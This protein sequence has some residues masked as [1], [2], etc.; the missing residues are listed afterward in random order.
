MR[1]Q[2]AGGAGER[3]PHSPGRGAG[4][5]T[6]SCPRGRDE[7]PAAGRGPPARPPPPALPPGHKENGSP[8]SVKKLERVAL[9]RKLFCSQ[10]GPLPPQTPSRTETETRVGSGL[11]TQRWLLNSLAP[12]FHKGFPVPCKHCTPPLSPHTSPHCGHGVKGRGGGG[13]PEEPR[14]QALAPRRRGNLS[15]ECSGA[16]CTSRGPGRES[17]SDLQGGDRPCPSGPQEA[18]SHSSLPSL[19]HSSTRSTNRY[20]RRV[21]CRLVLGWS[22]RR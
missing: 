14:I 21:T 5:G 12:H 20:R 8:I 15:L 18:G 2:G 10:E 11:N 4:Q 13:R 9:A 16:S 19:I 22:A 6:A 7:P 1:S 17:G 3:P